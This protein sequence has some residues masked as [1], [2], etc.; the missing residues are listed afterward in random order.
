[1]A[2]R[3]ASR[4]TSKGKKPSASKKASQRKSPAKGKSLGILWLLLILIVVAVAII[5]AINIKELYKEEI[6]NGV[7][8]DG[9][10][11]SGLTKEDAY[12]TIKKAAEDKLENISIIFRYNDKSWSFKAEDLQASIDYDSVVEQ[13][14]DAGKSEG[15]LDR[16]KEY[17]DIQS[18]GLELSTTFI[19]D[20]Q[21]L[22]R[23]LDNVKEEIDHPMVEPFIIF[24]PTGI[25]YDEFNDPEFDEIAAMFTI[26]EGQVGYAMDYD[27]AIED[28][29]EQL[30]TGWNAD[31]TIIVTEQHPSVD[32][33]ELEQYTTLVYHSSSYLNSSKRQNI[34]RNHNIKKAIDTYKG[35]VLMPGDLVSYNE[36]LGQRTL[37][38][39]WLEAPTIARD[40]TLIDEVGGGICQSATAIFNAA[41]MADAKIIES[42]PHSW[43]AYYH[44]YGYAMDAMVNWGT[45]D[46]IFQND[47]DYPMFINTYFW[48]SPTTGLPGYVDVDIYSMPQKDEAGNILHIRS[49]ATEVRREA[50]KPMVYEQI[51]E[52]TA[53][54]RF[55]TAVWT[56]DATL[57][58]M[59]FEQIT[60]RDL[61]EY[62]V[63]RVWYKDCEP[64]DTKG[65][66]TD[67]VEV[68]REYAHT[69]I[70]KAI[71][72]KTFTKPMPTPP[73]ATPTP[74]PT[75]T[76]EVTG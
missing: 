74:T 30:A 60:P 13:A 58:M 34:N 57:N 9:K 55:P 16:F 47:S 21:V 28:L 50:P 42:N 4:R 25:E 26:T 59:V 56:H 49:E 71:T 38:S 14:Y 45:S 69:Y 48:Y 63:D 75:A 37:E 51:D 10:D 33:K 8:I 61:V 24:D 62:S 39:G 52:A 20:K 17:Q 67:G 18:D 70:Y 2:K 65:V 76:P 29:N 22:I 23:A 68:K 46:F 36:I 15:I 31:I 27:K 3:T 73:P 40:K 1:M 19:V 54:E 44:D 53:L 64:T 72:G 32:I 5:G 41:F 7:T 12:E 11:V 43:A 66:W 35:L 6:L